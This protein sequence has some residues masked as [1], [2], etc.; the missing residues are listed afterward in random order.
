MVSKQVN[1]STVKKNRERENSSPSD[2][3]NDSLQAAQYFLCTLVDPTLVHG[4]SSVRSLGE[5]RK[6]GTT[7]ARKTSVIVVTRLRC[8]VANHRWQALNVGLSKRCRSVTFP[9]AGYREKSLLTSFV[10]G[11]KRPSSSGTIRKM[12]LTVSSGWP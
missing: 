8:F 9:I 12:T 6:A 2:F 7:Y 5:S 4:C 3:P 10:H 11:L 1:T